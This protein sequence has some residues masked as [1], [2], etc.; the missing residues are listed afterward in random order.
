MTLV[1]ACRNVLRV[2]SA[3]EG[4]KHDENLGSEISTVG[5]KQFIICHRK[6]RAVDRISLYDVSWI[7]VRQYEEASNLAQS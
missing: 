7:S 6:R 2:S 5:Q 3:E 1:V 4:S